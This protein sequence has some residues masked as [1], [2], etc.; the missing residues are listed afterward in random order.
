MHS[1]IVTNFLLLVLSKARVDLGTD[2]LR[3][4]LIHA[5]DVLR[6]ADERIFLE[7][8]LRLGI[9]DG[10]VEAIDKTIRGHARRVLP[11]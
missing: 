10:R 9:F 8:D 7:L 4:Q 6:D 5:I 2:V 3:R 11:H 1:P